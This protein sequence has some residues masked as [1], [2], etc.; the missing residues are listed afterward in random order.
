MLTSVAAPLLNQMAQMCRTKW[1]RQTLRQSPEGLAMAEDRLYKEAQTKVPQRAAMAYATVMPLLLENRAISRFLAKTQR[2]DL[3][4]ALPEVTTP[5]EA[6]ALA[7]TEF[8]LTSQ[9]QSALLNLLQGD[10]PL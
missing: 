5:S 1:A 4:S 9:E 8:N 7:S 6:V 3:R 10:L 2:P